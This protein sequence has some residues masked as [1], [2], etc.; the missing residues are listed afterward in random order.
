MQLDRLLLR[1]LRLLQPS[2]ASDVLPPQVSSST[3]LYCVRVGT[4]S[5]YEHCYA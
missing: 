3:V 1:T 4:V 2:V 5:T